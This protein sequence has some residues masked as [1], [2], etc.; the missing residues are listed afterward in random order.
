MPTI[1]TD[2]PHCGASNAAFNVTYA[3]PHYLRRESW[4]TLAI[5]PSCGCGIY[6]VI[7]AHPAH[8]TIHNL[9]N[10]Q[11]N[12]AL[13]DEV[14]SI[15]VFPKAEQVEAPEHIPPLATR[16]FVE[17]AESLNAGRP[18]AAAAMFRR[19][20][21]IALKQHSPDIEAWKLDKRID[22]LFAEGRITKDLQEWAHRIRLEGNDA[23]HEEE[24]FTKETASEMME[25]TRM[26]L[27]YLYTLPERIRIRVA[28]ADAAKAD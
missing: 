19:C 11:G 3:N 27:V 8:G 1:V 20:L 4:N 7:S 5:C 9:Q 6:A 17:G 10:I 2:C 21:E 25:F 13:H 18:T 28:A 23:L 16:A 15:E 22:K 26:V 12:L 14:Y 24:E